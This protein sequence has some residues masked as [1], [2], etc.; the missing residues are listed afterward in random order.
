MNFYLLFLILIAFLLGLSYL[1]P[2][3]K[4][5]FQIAI[6]VLGIAVSGFRDWVGEDFRSYVGWYETKSRDVDSEIGFTL[7]M[8]VLRGLGLSYH[9]LF[10]FFSFST[11]L[12]VFLA[13]KK[14]T[15]QSSLAFFFFLV[16]P[17]LYLHSWSL[18]RQAFACAIGFYAFHYLITKKY[19][20]YILL[21]GIAMSIHVTAII[22]FVV[23]ILVFLLADKIT[24]VYLIIA[25]FLSLAL[26]QIQWFQFFSNW[27]SG[28]RYS[29]YFSSEIPPSSTIKLIVLNGLA[30][31][32]LFFYNK[33]KS[34]YPFHNY[35]M[36][37]CLISVFI[38]NV[39]A[40]VNDFTRF[41]YYFYIFQIVV[42]ADLVFLE[43]K[44]KRVL[45]FTALFSYGIA[46]FFYTLIMDSKINSQNT[47][48]I[49]YNSVFYKFDNPFFMIGTDCLIDSN[50]KASEGVDTSKDE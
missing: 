35:I 25:L 1:Y 4:E 48:Y 47:K 33:M 27:F 39:F 22:P 16:I 36:L 44:Y 41:A 6:L 13:A 46:S 17:F 20:T 43:I 2:N 40:S 12:L 31:F 37:L 8:N 11:L 18:I 50:L 15:K 34:V 23:F 32:L 30:V 10:F 7:I 26:S 5:F 38:T 19:L 3:K 29:Y 45:L 21:M 24:I 9:F 42:F 28:T 14:Y 49:P